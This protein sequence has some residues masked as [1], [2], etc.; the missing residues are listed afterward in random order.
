MFTH[1]VSLPLESTIFEKKNYIYKF[2]LLVTG[3][4]K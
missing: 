1:A 3:N 4:Q 2:K